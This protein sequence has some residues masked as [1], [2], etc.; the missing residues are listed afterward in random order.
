MGRIIK[1]KLHTGVFL[2]GANLG[3]DLA[4]EGT[5]KNVE[6]TMQDMFLKITK[7]KQSILVPFTNV[8]QITMIEDVKPS[9]EN[10]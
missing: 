1:A 7:N 5:T 6:M 8:V 3:T 2:A 10:S 9:E 4:T